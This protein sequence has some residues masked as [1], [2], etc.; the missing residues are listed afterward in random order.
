MKQTIHPWGKRLFS[1]LLILILLSGG[2]AVSEESAPKQTG[3]RSLARIMASDEGL[4]AVDISGNTWA[5][6]RGGPQL[7]IPGI[8]WNDWIQKPTAIAV[9]NVI[10]VQSCGYLNAFL[11]ADGEVWLAGTPIDLRDASYDKRQENLRRVPIEGV[12]EICLSYR[13]FKSIDDEMLLMLKEDGSLWVRG[14]KSGFFELETEEKIIGFGPAEMILIHEDG[15]LHEYSWDGSRLRHDKAFDLPEGLS[16]LESGVEY[17]VDREGALYQRSN[18]GKYKKHKR[19]LPDPDYSHVRKLYSSAVLYDDGR[20]LVWFKNEWVRL[21]GEFADIAYSGWARGGIA[22]LDTD[23]NVFT[24]DG[25]KYGYSELMSATPTKTA[26][27]LYQAAPKRKAP[28]LPGEDYTLPNGTPRA[29]ADPRAYSSSALYSKFKAKKKNG[30][31]IYKPSSPQPL[32]VLITTADGHAKWGGDQPDRLEEWVEKTVKDSQGLLRV[33]TDPTEADVMIAIQRKYFK[34]TYRSKAG[35][36]VYVYNCTMKITAVMLTDTS[37]KASISDKS[38]APNSFKVS[39]G[40]TAH[41]EPDP[42]FSNFSSLISKILGWYGLNCK[43]GSKGAGAKRV[44]QALKARQFYDGKV[45][46]TFGDKCVQALKEFQESLGYEATG[47]VDR[48]TLIW[49][50]YD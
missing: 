44:Q 15:T 21:E 1:A 26:L 32:N 30:L 9:K 17:A 24:I 34:L 11:T 41:Y 7:G 13:G 43:K 28:K 12:K 39:S 42:S 33:V 50:Y 10:D 37:L 19:N 25:E 2:A 5:W 49:L 27:N 36:K 48:D 47:I 16:L 35:K 40:A 38:I 22:L 18:I 3:D 20:V 45:D 29:Q 31:P 6:G 23:G 8:G 14:E 4:F 46:G